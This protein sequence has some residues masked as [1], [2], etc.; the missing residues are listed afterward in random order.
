MAHLKEEHDI[1]K[2]CCNLCDELFCVKDALVVPMNAKHGII[3]HSCDGC[4]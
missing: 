2:H 4:D 1:N 3:E